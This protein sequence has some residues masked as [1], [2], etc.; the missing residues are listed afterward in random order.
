[1]HPF[2]VPLHNSVNHSSEQCELKFPL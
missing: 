2:T 1:M